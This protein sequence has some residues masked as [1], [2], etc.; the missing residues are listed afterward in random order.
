MDVV[1]NVFAH[2]FLTDGP[3]E[4][5]LG[6]YVDEI[7]PVDNLLAINE[8]GHYGHCDFDGDGVDDDFLATGQT[9]WF[10]SAG[11]ALALPEHLARVPV[12]PAA[13]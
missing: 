5:A 7:T 10:R 13:R 6:G 12:G 11:P 4:S 3:T 8:N 9:W 2:L 1:S